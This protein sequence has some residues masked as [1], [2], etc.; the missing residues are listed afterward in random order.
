[1]PVLSSS[2]TVGTGIAIQ[3]GTPSVAL[4]TDAS[5]AGVCKVQADQ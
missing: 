3:G 2:R 4:A 5:L 1:M